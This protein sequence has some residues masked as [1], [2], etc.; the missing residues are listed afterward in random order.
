MATIKALHGS[1]SLKN[2]IDYVTN[3]EKAEVITSVNC[4]VETAFSEMETTKNMY[5]KTGGR[6]YIHLVQSWHKDEDFF[7]DITE[8]QKEKI[9]KL[10]DEEQIKIK[11]KIAN[12]IAQKMIKE[13]P[14]FKGYEVIIAT[15]IDREHIHNHII[16]NSVNFENGYKFQSS[17]HDLQVIKDKSD[18]ICLQYGLS[19]TEKGKTFER[20]E[21]KNISTYTKEARWVQERAKEKH[22]DSYIYRIGAL[23]S[24][25]RKIATNKEEFI[26]ILEKNNIGVKWEDNRKYI[27]FTD[28]EREKENPKK[29]KVR[30]KSLNQYFGLGISKDT[31]SKE[32]K[33][34]QNQSTERVKEYTNIKSDVNIKANTIMANARKEIKN[35]T[36]ITQARRITRQIA[37]G[38]TSTHNIDII[39]G[40]I[41]VLSQAL[42]VLQSG[43]GG[44]VNLG[45]E[46][47]RASERAEIE[48]AI[49][50]LQ[51]TLS[52]ETARAEASIVLSGR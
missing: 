1:K 25:A 31:L 21:H 10:S 19:K 27:T 6:T 47:T 3:P 26:E 38:R 23:V 35:N 7:A 29:C 50:T 37:G 17:A 34:K 14:L 9:A 44:S 42:S 30:D 36:V 20:L 41:S 33:T 43:S 15:H 22:I 51:S 8:E 52:S 48:Q 39:R 12:E 45:L 28:I 16:V 24:K 2:A 11:A 46:M 4:N 32:F 49:N 18:E 13:L 40:Q 5:G